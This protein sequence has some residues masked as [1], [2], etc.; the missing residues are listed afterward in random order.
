MAEKQTQ[1]LSRREREKQHH[2]DEIVPAAERVFVRKGYQSATMEEIAQEAEFAVGT[3]Y[4]FFKG[5][6]EL[7]FQILLR[8]AEQFI[9]AM[10]KEVMNGSDPTEA[11]SALIRLRLE[12]FEE[13][14]GFFRV[15]LER[16]SNMGVDVT[17]AMPAKDKTSVLEGYKQRY[18]DIV[19]DLFARGIASGQFAEA[20]PIYLMFCLEGAFHAYANYWH[21]READESAEVRIEKLARTFLRGVMA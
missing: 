5:K 12:T 16:S 8:G 17:S 10:E 3:I 2:R 6:D 15:I 19:T 18:F 13:H 9:S 4:N 21:D 1:T 11:L 7:Y 20:D 14:R